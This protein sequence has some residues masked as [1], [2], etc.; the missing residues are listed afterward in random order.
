MDLIVTI[1]NELKQARLAREDDRRDALTLILS[2]LRSAEKELQRPLSE[3]EELQVLQRERN[4]ALGGAPPW[5]APPWRGTARRA[6]AGEWPPGRPVGVPAALL[7][8]AAE[9]ERRGLASRRRRPAEP[10]EAARAPATGSLPITVPP[11]LPPAERCARA[12]ERGRRGAGRARDRLLLARGPSGRR[13]LRRLAAV[14][15]VGDHV[16]GRRSRCFARQSL[17][18]L[19]ENW[20]S[21]F[22]WFCETSS[23]L[24]PCL[25]CSR[26]CFVAGV[27]LVTRKT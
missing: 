22:C 4:A 5:G 15:A 7:G 16:V 2:S 12:V 1:E 14:A 23:C 11:P 9:R 10:A 17:R 13:G 8:R 19:V 3:D 21:S 20:S 6:A 18:K 24:M 26:L 27:T 25:D